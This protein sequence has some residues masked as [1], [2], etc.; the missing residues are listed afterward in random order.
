MEPPSTRSI[1][2]TNETG[3][4]IQ[5]QPIRRA[6]SAALKRHGAEG[7]TVSVLL[8]D[9]AAMRDLNSR[10]RGVDESTDVL[11]FPTFENDPLGDIAIAVPYAEKQAQARGVA[12]VQELGYL[13][14]HGTLHLL[15]FDDEAEIDRA[16]MIQKMNEAAVDAGLTPDE[17]WHSILHYAEAKP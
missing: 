10:F 2:I 12:L 8:T 9:D 15:G 11:S 14:I 13:A 5:L 3:R 1:H 6:V 17:G 7:A 16:Q 4:R